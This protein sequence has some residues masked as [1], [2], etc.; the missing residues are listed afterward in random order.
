MRIRILDEIE[1]CQPSYWQS[2]SVF[3]TDK[4]LKYELNQDVNL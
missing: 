1:G 2:L 3:E 4:A